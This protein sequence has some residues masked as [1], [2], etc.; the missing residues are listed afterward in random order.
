MK[1]FAKTN[2]YVLLDEGS[3]KQ[4][5]LKLNARRIDLNGKPVLQTIVIFDFESNGNLDV[6]VW[7]ENN[8]VFNSISSATEGFI[9]EAYKRL[10]KMVKISP[11]SLISEIT[12]VYT[13]T[14]MGF[15]D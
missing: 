11:A 6:F 3:V 10:L 5:G 14:K 13:L 15:L 1:L 2:T 8:L 12:R 7:K 4:I 9:V